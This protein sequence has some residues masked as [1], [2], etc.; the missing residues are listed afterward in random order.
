MTLKLNKRSFSRYDT[1]KKEW[2][3]DSGAYGILAGASSSDIRLTEE[4]I[5]K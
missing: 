5:L 2:V 1:S 4:I 3:A